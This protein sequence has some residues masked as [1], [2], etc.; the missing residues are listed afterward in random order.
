METMRPFEN[1]EL[2]PRL[3][4]IATNILGRG[5]YLFYLVGSADT[6]KGIQGKGYDFG[7]E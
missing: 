2:A 7:I 1:Q 5:E 4:K 6:I 3:Y